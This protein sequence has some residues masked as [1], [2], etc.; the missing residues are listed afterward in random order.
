MS[1]VGGGRN[2]EQA[3]ELGKATG[4]DE[5]AIMSSACGDRIPEKQVKDTGEGTS[6]VTNKSTICLRLS[7]IRQIPTIIAL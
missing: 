1:S 7:E 6:K 4:E 3:K 2:P 5:S